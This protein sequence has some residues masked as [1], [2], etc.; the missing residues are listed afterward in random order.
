MIIA[1]AG[2]GAGGDNT[3]PPADVQ[4]APVMCAGERLREAGVSLINAN[5]GEFLILDLLGWILNGWTV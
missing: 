2:G 4:A 1:Q 3:F 5:R